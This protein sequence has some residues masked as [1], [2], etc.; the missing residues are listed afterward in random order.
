MIVWGVD[1]R[2]DPPNGDVPTQP[3]PIA[4]PVAFKSLLDSN[5]GGVTVPGHPGVQN[6]AFTIE[7][8]SGGFVVSYIPVGM[9]VPYRTTKGEEYYIRAGSEFR[10]APHAVLAGLFGRPPHPNLEIIV[11]YAKIRSVKT[12]CEL[13]LDLYIGNRGRGLAEDFFFTCEINTNPDLIIR[14]DPRE[15]SWKWWDFDRSGT[16]CISGISPPSPPL[17]PGSELL[18]ATILI[19]GPASYSRWS[20]IGHEVW[21]AQR[22]RIGS[23]DY[24]Y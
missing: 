20:Y 1:C 10:R 12:G 21:C 15:P 4:N 3:R 17:P 2:S 11:R 22:T 19:Q 13:I 8:Q 24:V 5:V 18:I 7:G 9:N 16:K 23:H 6:L 14:L